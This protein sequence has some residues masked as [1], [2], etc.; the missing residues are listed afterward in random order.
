MP[1]VYVVHLRRPRNRDDSRDDPF[2]ECGSFGLT[3]CHR[4]NL[5]HKRHAADLQGAR[6]A[7]VQG[8]G[9]GMRLLFLTPPVR[10]VQHPRCLEALWPPRQ[11]PFRYDCAPLIVDK[12]G[13][14]DLRFL[15]R[16]FDD[17]KR[18][19]LAARFSS[20]FRSRA[21]P[22]PDDIAE[23]LLRSYRKLSKDRPRAKKY[24]DALPRQIARPDTGRENTYQRLLERAR[25]TTKRAAAASAGRRC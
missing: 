7:F 12:S 4:H 14:S 19:T 13:G 23:K 11:M 3:Y 10:V 16:L 6:L 17:A 24:T 8:G 20:K 9:V 18:G 21:T 25:K 22:F 15:L 2:W 1:K 5:L